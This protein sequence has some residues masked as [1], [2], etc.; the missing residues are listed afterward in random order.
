MGNSDDKGWS[1]PGSTRT[2]IKEAKYNLFE[3]FSEIGLNMK[4]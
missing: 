3:L 1:I 2:V 4:Y